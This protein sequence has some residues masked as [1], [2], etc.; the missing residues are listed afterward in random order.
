MT[1]DPAYIRNLRNIIRADPQ[2]SDLEALEQELY[3]STSDRATAVLFGAFVDD[4][5]GR[6]LRSIMRADLNSD[7]ARRLFDPEG[8][9]GSF[10]SRI[11]G[12]YAL[13]LIGPTTRADLDLIRLIR[14]AFAHSKMPFGFNTPQARAACDHL[15]IVDLPGSNMPFGYLNCVPDAG[16]N[17]ALDKTDPKTRF[18]ST[19]H[20]VS[21]RMLVKRDGPKAGDRVFSGDLLP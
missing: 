7:D 10:S 15:K 12:A 8:P 13:K 3:V 6:L 18:I 21:Y 4:H 16:L 9:F 11:L 20:N 2:L 19:C 1:A 17:A 5:L 14:N